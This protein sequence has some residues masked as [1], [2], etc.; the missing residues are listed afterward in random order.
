MR[1]LAQMDVSEIGAQAEAYRV[2]MDGELFKKGV[3]DIMR[4]DAMRQFQAGGVP[5]WD[6]LSPGTV[7]RKRS[8]GYVR[9]NRK[10]AAVEK[11]LQEGNFRPEN[12]LISTG[13]LLTS[14]T[15]AKD[16]FHVEELG[17]ED[18]SIGSDLIYASTHQLGYSG[19]L[20][21]GR[22]N[23]TIP[24]RPIRVTTRG[25]Q[26]VSKLLEKVMKEVGEGNS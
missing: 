10:S 1:I 3:A 22:A 16:N 23:G 8:A 20:F 14:W 6:E 25:E 18:V 24:A 5:Q 12:K 13:A 26:E 4:A 11:L 9:K 19:P 7:K 15:D 2:A 17:D 21:G